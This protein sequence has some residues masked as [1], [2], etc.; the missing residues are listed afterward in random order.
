MI[1]ILEEIRT[2]ITSKKMNP[3][4]NEYEID[5]FEKEHAVSLPKDYR[6]FLLN[7]ANGGEGPPEYGLLKLGE[8]QILDVPD[9]LLDGYASRLSQ[10]FPLTEYWVWEGEQESPDF[11]QK[12]QAT[13]RGCLV[14]GHDGCG[15]YWLLIVT[16]E[17]RGQIWQTTDVGVLPCV[18][19]L[20]FTQWYLKW[21][22]GDTDWW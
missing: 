12:Y 11:A 22:K 1:D 10:P 7:I 15:M 17:S 6:D 16:G 18:P 5:L 21:L 3:I 2:L 20:T 19:R 4:L 14:L 8:I 13:E 9:Y